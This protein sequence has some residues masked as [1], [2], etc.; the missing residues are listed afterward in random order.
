MID[1]PIGSR[2]SVR[3]ALDVGGDTFLPR[4]VLFLPCGQPVH[5]Q[6]PNRSGNRGML[7]NSFLFDFYQ[8]I[9]VEANRFNEERFSTDFLFFCRNQMYAARKKIGKFSFRYI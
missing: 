9:F 4:T 5:Q 3:I 7:P 8:N 1:S 6:D 2:S